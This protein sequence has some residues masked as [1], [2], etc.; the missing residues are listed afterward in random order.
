MEAFMINLPI[1]QKVSVQT[2]SKRIPTYKRSLYDNV[3]FNSKL[4]G[5]KGPRGSGKSTLLMQYAHSTKI[6]TSKML[7]ISCDHPAM[8][9]VSLYDLAEQFYVK[10][11]KL[12][13]IDEIHKNTD[14]ARQLKAIYDVFDLQVV[15]SG[16]SALHI[17][18]SQIDLSRRA[19]LHHLGVLSLREFI[20]LSTK[21]KFNSYTLEE[22]LSNHIDIATSIMKTIRPLEQ[23]ELYLQHG[24]YPFY[25]E[26]LDDYPQKLLEV[27]NLTIDSDL[28]GIYKIDPTKLDKLKKI[29]YM[30]CS[31]KPYE[32]NISKLSSAVGTSWVTLSKYLERMDAGSLI[33]ILRGGQGMR[34]VNKPDKLLLDNPNLFT[35]LCANPDI[36][37]VR[38]SFFVSQTSLKHQVHYHD[39]GDFVIDD[40]IVCEVGGSSKDQTQL[41]NQKNSFI[42]ADNIEIGYENKI[43]LWLFGFLY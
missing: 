13:I 30:L 7:Y 5:I 8:V 41:Q 34:A 20:E 40:N 12:L 35:V 25:K 6:S 32:L 21:K 11:G 29:M 19:V 42:I 38:E 27:I 22:I 16:S 26:S 14:F 37:S 36:G 31:T 3:D 9:G 17:E 2:L 18:N 1:L 43:P 23:F 33:H 28:C 15:F 10:G 4:I 39:K 24:C